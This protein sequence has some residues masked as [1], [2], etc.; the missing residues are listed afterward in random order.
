MSSSIKGQ[1]YHS[2]LSIRYL[3]RHGKSIDDYEGCCGEFVDDIIHWLGE[4]NVRIMYLRGGEAGIGPR[5]MW[6]YHMVPVID[7]HVHDAWFPDHVLPPEEYVHSVFA[8]QNAEI[9]FPV[10]E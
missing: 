2:N 9:S 5:G 6:S 3:Q 4:G 1:T 10:E 8:G 7:G